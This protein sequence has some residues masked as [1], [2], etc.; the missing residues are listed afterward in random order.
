[1]LKHRH[2][3]P[4]LLLA[5]LL[6][7]LSGCAKDSTL[8]VPPAHQPAIPPLPSQARQVDSPTW[9]ASA[10]TDIEKWLQSLTEPSSPAGPVKPPTKR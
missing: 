4:G 9:S 8:F 6:A 7:L 2:S 5:L 10:Q 3:R 1:M